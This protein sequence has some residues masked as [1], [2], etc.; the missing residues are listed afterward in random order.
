MTRLSTFLLA[1]WLSAAGWLSAQAVSGRIADEATG[2]ALAGANILVRHTFIGT[3][4]DLNGRFRLE[5]VPDT[6]TLV[7]TMMGYEKALVTV[8]GARKTPLEIR[9][10]RDVLEAPQV[11]VTASRK[12]QD[13]LESPVSVSVITPLNIREQAAVSLE[14]ILPYASGV[15]II[16]N[17]LN[18]RGASG[19]TLGAGSRSLLLLDGVPLLGSAAGNITWAIVPTSEIAQVEIVKSGGSALYGSSAMGGVVNIL[20]R[21]A[22]AHPEYRFRTKTGFYSPPKYKQW[23]WRPSRGWITVNEITAARPFG[24]HSGWLRFQQRYTD[25]FTRLGWKQALNLTGKVKLNFGS[26]RT[27]TLYGNWLRDR[28]GLESQWKSA[29]EPF[30]APTAAVHDI[31]QGTKLNLNGFFN[32]V[33]TPRTGA[34]IIASLYQVDWS[35]SGT[36]RDYSHERRQYLE[37]QVA[38]APAPRLNITLGAALQPT[39]IRARLFGNHTG[40]TVAAYGL[41]QQKIARPLTLTLGARWEQF[42]V[43][44]QP[45]GRRLAPQVAINAVLLPGLALRASVSSGFRT[46]TLA[47]RFTHSQLSVFKVEPNP[48]LDPETSVT[49]EVGGT[50]VIPSRGW[51]SGL[52]LDGAVYQYRFENLI[53]PTPDAFGIIHFEN[54]TRARI[55]GAE[56]SA[57]ISFWDQALRLGLA[58]TWLDPVELNGRGA[59]V[60]TLSYRHRRHLVPSLRFHA[61]AF[62]FSVDGR[63]ASA[64]EKTEL[65]SYDPKT[66]RDPRVPVKIW[67]AGLG[68]EGQRLSIL[69]RVENLFQYYYVE[70]ERNMGSERNGTL[71]INWVY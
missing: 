14:E 62:S 63:R 37:G 38:L 12:V 50:W 35:N 1:L 29:A 65:Y 15:N 17:Q 40:F 28:G 43:D 8:T 44:G 19:F 67:N 16:K 41:A 57:Y 24:P 26:S 6:A 10:K 18:I 42:Q 53:E 47:E 60:D 9:L 22:P 46:P 2:E 70:L 64:I 5:S 31:S 61:G 56:F 23:D 55:T 11:V 39:Q 30:E 68:W 49:G 21:N 4:S 52:R 20:T 13:V 36:N 33:L 71:S 45:R 59:V 34:K 69:L 54:L 25:G 58:Y 51:I 32:W 48:D 7:I 66:G 27:A 3:A